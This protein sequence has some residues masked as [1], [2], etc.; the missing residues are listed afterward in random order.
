MKSAQQIIDNVIVR[1]ED[2]EYKF[3]STSDLVLAFNN[4]LD[5]IADAT[6]INELKAMVKRKKG[7]PYADLRG[8][9]GPN[10][11][12]VTAVWNP[13]TN[14]WLEPITV[15]ELDSNHGRFWEGRQDSSR[16]WF[17]RGLYYLGTYPTC[18]DDTSPLRIHY[19]ATFPH[20][21][22]NG[23]L[24]TGLT[25][26]PD[27]P[28]DFSDAIENHMLYELFAQRKE[29]QKSL[30]HYRD[31]VTHEKMLFDLANNRMR[32]DKIPTIGARRT[33][34]GFGARR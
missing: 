1:L 2:P 19:S 6:E 17:M 13:N 4:A 29:T 23:G 21:V 27:L 22:E 10:A 31:Y 33:V 14:R 28:P 34:G 25:S 3:F 18:P 9:L 7:A 24:V 8:V 20:V 12:R 30:A 11:L 32:R 5:E 16:W 15:E 26:K